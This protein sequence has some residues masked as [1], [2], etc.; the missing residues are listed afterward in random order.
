MESGFRALIFV[1]N[2][3]VPASV[4]TMQNYRLPDVRVVTKTK[5]QIHGNFSEDQKLQIVKESF[6]S[7]MSIAAN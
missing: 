2:S 7:G 6:A 4:L 5:T 1:G 3:K